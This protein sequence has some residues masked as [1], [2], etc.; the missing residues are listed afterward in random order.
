MPVVFPCQNTV[1]SLGVAGQIQ[2]SFPAWCVG[3]AALFMFMFVRHRHA[4]FRARMIRR[5][6]VKAVCIYD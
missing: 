3:D 1:I 5:V 4:N 2:F 6:C